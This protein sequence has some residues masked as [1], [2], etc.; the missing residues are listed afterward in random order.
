MYTLRENQRCLRLRN[1]AVHEAERQDILAWKEYLDHLGDGA[2]NDDAGTVPFYKPSQ[3]RPIRALAD[4]D[5]M[6]R[7]IFDVPDSELLCQ[8][9]S[10]WASRCIVTPRHTSVD[11]LNARML[12]RM[13]GATIPCYS[14]DR[15][16]E[17]SVH[18]Q[19]GVEFLNKQ[20]M[21]GFPPHK[22]D[23]KVGAVV[24]LLRNLDRSRG[25]VNGA[26]MLLL[27]IRSNRFLRA[28][29]L[30]GTHIGRIVLIPRISLKASGN[31]F[32]F[33]WK[34]LQ[35]PV[36]LAYCMTINKSQGQTLSSIAIF[37]ASMVLNDDGLLLRAEPQPCFAHGQ[38]LVAFSRVGHPDRVS[39]FLDSTQMHVQRTACP[40]LLQALLPSSVED[41][42]A[43]R[44]RDLWLQWV[45]Q[46][47]NPLPM[48]R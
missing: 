10:F 45:T 32:S 38:L 29:L 4:V 20:S 9:E 35:F 31:R 33:E 37:L 26:R 17:E 11:F 24:M 41:V 12:A 30:T 28:K 42:Q 14:V 3:C 43:Q 27:E 44:D 25:M 34:R 15:L 23:L 8:T 36:K 48:C 2:L 13:P 47:F 40:I 46:D 16:S 6:L 18:L 19:L 5:T 7:S 22:L 1:L 21:P 39:V